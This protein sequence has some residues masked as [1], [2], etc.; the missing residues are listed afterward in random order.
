MVCFCHPSRLLHL[1]I[2]HEDELFAHQLI[3]LFPK[4]V[5]DIQNNLYQVQKTQPHPLLFTP[6][7]RVLVY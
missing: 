7:T 6:S 5:L 2:I 3:Q 4:D 1:A